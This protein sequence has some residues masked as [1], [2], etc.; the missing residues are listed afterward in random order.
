MFDE[1]NC[2]EPC[3]PIE[4]YPKKTIKIMCGLP[5]SGQR[6]LVISLQILKHWQ[7]KQKVM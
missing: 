3:V 6:F 7:K 5:R 4:V 1:D 2:C